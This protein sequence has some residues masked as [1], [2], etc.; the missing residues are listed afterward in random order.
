MT[1]AYAQADIDDG[2]GNQDIALAEWVRRLAEQ[3]LAHHPGE[4]WLYGLNTDVLGRLIE[5][6]SG[7]SLDR[8]FAERIFTPLG[9]T[10]THF[11]VPRDQHERIA[12]VHRRGPDG[13]LAPVPDGLVIDDDTRFDVSYPYDGRTG[14]LAGGAGLT[15]TATDYARFLQML[16]NGGELDGERLL[17]RKTVELML[18]NQTGHLE[19]SGY[20][21]AGFTLGFGLSWGPERGQIVSAGTLGWGGFF[22]T[23]AWF[24]PREQLIGILLTQQYPYGHRLMNTYRVAIYQ[25]LVE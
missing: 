3:P 14:F 19:D 24:D 17:G 10:A 8:F 11:E 7:Q 6:T 2:L 18:A 21:A 12:A 1:S 25:A 22:S 9:M 15:S 5:V 20:G 23:D 4:A 13:R 16:L